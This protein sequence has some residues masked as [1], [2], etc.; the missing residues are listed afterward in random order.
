MLQLVGPASQLCAAAA[1]AGP[2]PLQESA[3]AAAGGDNHPQWLLQTAQALRLSLLLS[4]SQLPGHR[5]GITGLCSPYLL[6][7][8]PGG[9]L[10]AGRPLNVVAFSPSTLLGAVLHVG[11]A[12]ASGCNAFH[13]EPSPKAQVRSTVRPA[14]LTASKT[15]HTMGCMFASAALV[16]MHL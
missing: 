12:P 7:K 11:H 15:S 10:G 14:P 2:C 6:S 8:S 4:V 5:Q 1:W 9:L 3:P 13:S 16:C